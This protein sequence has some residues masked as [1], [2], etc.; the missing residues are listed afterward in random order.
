MK[1][2]KIIREPA[3]INRTTARVRFSE[4]DSMHVVWH[5]NYVHYM[6]DGREAFGQEFGI[7]YMEV[8]KQGY[9]I[10]IVKLELDYKQALTYDEHIT[11]ETRYIPTDAAKIQFEYFIYKEDGKT[12]AAIGRTIQ[13]FVEKETQQLELSNPAFYMAWKEKWNI[14]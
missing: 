8:V 6:E 3:L 7:S 5:G 4:V 10:P 13:V 2:K 11:I 1:Q 9:V 12:I 14:R